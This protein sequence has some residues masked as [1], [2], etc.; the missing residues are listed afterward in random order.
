MP[1]MT[2]I[3]THRLPPACA[4]LALMNYLYT[5]VISSSTLRA[6]TSMK[7]CL[8]GYVYIFLSFPCGCIIYRLA[9]H[10]PYRPCHEGDNMHGTIEQVYLLTPMDRAT[11]PHIRP[12]RAAHTAV[13]RVWSPLTR[14]QASVDI[15]SIMLH[16]PTAVGC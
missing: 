3:L 6:Y 13:R 12:H 10:V 4:K 7:I 5:P 2:Y 14:Q 16:R 11:L 1:P 9:F 8:T 15:E